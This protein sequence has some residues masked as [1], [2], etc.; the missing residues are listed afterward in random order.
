MANLYPAETGL[1][2]T[3]WV[4]PRGHARHDARIKV[5]MTHGNKMTVDNTAVVAIRPSP[6]VVTGRLSTED[7]QSVFR[8]ISLN[9]PMLIAYR[10]GEIGT[11]QLAQALVPLGS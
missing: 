8:W 10:D 11:I 7:E 6:R 9:S 5:N 2:M 3:V 4:S 1:P